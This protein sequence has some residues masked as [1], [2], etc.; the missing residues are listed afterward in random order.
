MIPKDMI[1]RDM[2]PDE[3]GLL[4]ESSGVATGRIVATRRLGCARGQSSG[5]DSA[6]LSQLNGVRH[7]YHHR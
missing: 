6:G 7:G 5:H 3:F 2:I 1:A 4:V